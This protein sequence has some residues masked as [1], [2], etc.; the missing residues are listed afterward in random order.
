MAVAGLFALAGGC[1][2]DTSSPVT[3]QG[4][5]SGE[6]ASPTTGGAGGESGGAGG[7]GGMPG[8]DFA[9]PC[10]TDEQ[11]EPGFCI[12]EETTGWPLG[13]CTELCND[14][15]PCAAPGTQCVDI[16]VGQFCLR[17]CV[18]SGDGAACEGHQQCFD[19]GNGAGVCG[20]GCQSDAHCPVLGHCDEDG[21]CTQRESCNDGLDNDHDDLAD[22]EDPDCALACQGAVDAACGAAT[23]ATSTQSGDTTGGTALFAGSCSGGL[24]ALEQVFAYTAPTEGLLNLKLASGTD[25]GVYVRGTC[26][27]PA[28]EIACADGVVG[29]QIESIYFPVASGAALS[30]FVDGFFSPLEAGPYDLVL[31]LIAFNSEVEQ[32]GAF[33]SANVH[34]DG[35]AFSAA[36]T[37]G[38]DD[39][40]AV[41]VPGPTSTLTA[42]VVAGGANRC[43]PAGGIDTELEILDTDG[44]TALAFNDDISGFGNFCSMASVDDLA[45]GTYF[46]RVSA[47]ADFCPDCAFDYNVVIAIE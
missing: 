13:Y 40:I 46:I 32:N 21:F 34:V 44:A 47:S 2:D 4:G 36:I 12:P 29:G 8:A 19:L 30:I 22:C 31:D 24:G 45:A 39:F 15:A 9:A 14:L 1:G 27:D 43:D 26:D 41:L 20:P 33:G 10:T 7:V 16:G 17:D 11:C 42:T 3:S 6:G 23:T 25:Q 18:P 37:T 35:T 38:D 28:T 5:A